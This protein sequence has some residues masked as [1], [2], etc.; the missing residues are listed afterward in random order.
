[1]LRTAR[2][3]VRA[4]FDQVCEVML[5]KRQRVTQTITSAQNTI[6][7]YSNLHFG[8]CMPGGLQHVAM[9]VRGREDAINNSGRQRY[10][11]A[12]SLPDA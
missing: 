9:A 4:F 3:F 8:R 11:A 5:D 10:N 6:P 12:W 2:D 1:M 7:L